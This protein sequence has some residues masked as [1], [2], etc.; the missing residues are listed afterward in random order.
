MTRWDETPRCLADLVV[1]DVV[2]R[3]RRVA[4][5]LGDGHRDGQGSRARA[6][7][8]GRLRGERA[9]ARG[10]CGGARGGRRSRGAYG[11]RTRV[12]HRRYVPYK[13][14]TA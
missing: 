1:I 8:A 9:R 12:W 10:G 2:R 7:R 3:A 4:K 11:W 5:S 6:L 13:I 14:Q